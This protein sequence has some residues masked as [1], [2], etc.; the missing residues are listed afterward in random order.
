MIRARAPGKL[1]LM[2]EHAVMYGQPCLVTAID[3]YLDVCIDQTHD[4]Q[5][6]IEAPQTDDDAR[7]I[8]EALRIGCHKLH[9]HHTGL[10]VQTTSQLTGY[11]LGASAAS[12]VATL[13]ALAERFGKN[14]TDKQLFSLAYQA[15]LA[16]QKKGSGFDV[17]A[18][19]WGGTLCYQN[20]GE[21]IEQL[22]IPTALPLVV[23]FSGTKKETVPLIEAVAKKHEEYPDAVNRIMEAIGKLVVQ[24]KHA[25]LASDVVSFGKFMDF[26]HE[27]L[28]DLGVSSERLEA[29]IAKA[30]GARA[31]G[32]KLSGAGAGDCMIALHPEG[33]AGK[34]AVAEAIEQAGGTVLQI[35]SH[36]EGVHIV[37]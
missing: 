4:G 7:F 23:G 18:S 32:A 15:V 27:Y 34:R 19:V 22:T 31:L 30:K 17:A 3:A 36:A 12:T 28:R 26:N 14:I 5:I 25:L 33:D 8:R 16:V 6:R 1:M 13:K 10:L 9:I 24:A 35:A 37:V 2:G 20:Q 29:M 21:V 11:G